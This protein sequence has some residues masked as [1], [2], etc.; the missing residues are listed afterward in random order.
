MK[1]AIR[2][3]NPV[4]FLQSAGRG[5]DLGDV[6]EGEWVV[7]LG[8]AD[9]KRTGSDVTVIAIGAMVRL[10]MRVAETLAAEGTSVEVVDPRTLRPLDTPALVKSARK[11]GRVVV[12]DEGR[13][14]AGMASEIAAIIAEEAFSSLRAPIRRVAAADVPIPFSP[15]L[16]RAVL[17]S[18]HR[19]LEAIRSTLRAD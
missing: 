13:L 16:E 7:P 14:S 11:T 9:V 8:V 15:D 2:D 6:P 19:L 3:D 5:G 1:A 18:E 10:A 12:V 4:V 17:P